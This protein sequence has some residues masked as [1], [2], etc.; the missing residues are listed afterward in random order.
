MFLS[1]FQNICQKI[2]AVYAEV[3]K[4]IIA[5]VTL[6]EV[7]TYSTKSKN[8]IQRIFLPI[9]KDIRQLIKAVKA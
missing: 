7:T 3:Q 4:S 9:V 6:T 1:N 2:K 5:Q 8:I